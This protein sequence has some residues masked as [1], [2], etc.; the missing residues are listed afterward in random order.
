MSAKVIAELKDFEAKFV[1]RGDYS[2]FKSKYAVDGSIAL[3][4][5]TEY[6][7]PAFNVTV[8]LEMPPFPGTF[9]VKQWSE[10]EGIVEELV[11]RGIL[12]LTGEEV[13][14]GFVEAFGA[15]LVPY[16]EECLRRNLS[17]DACPNAG[18]LCLDCC[19]EEH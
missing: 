17:T 13:R 11:K 4:A 5:T 10:N 16:C 2:L 12:R 1:E 18:D 15:Q 8:N 3:M 19:G 9:W 6:G 14:T 7:E